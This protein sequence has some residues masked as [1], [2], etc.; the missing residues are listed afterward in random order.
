M[1]VGESSH[2]PIGSELVVDEHRNEAGRP[3]V[4]TNGLTG[5]LDLQRQIL[6]ARASLRLGETFAEFAARRPQIVR[7][8]VE[9]II[10]RLRGVDAFDVLELLRNREIMAARLGYSEPEVPANPKTLE[11]VGTIL[12]ARGAR[13]V[14]TAARSDEG[15]RAMEMLHIVGSEIGKAGTFSALAEAGRTGD[16]WARLG[17]AFRL[18]RLSILNLHYRSIDDSINRRLFGEGAFA[19]A[20]SQRL[21]FTWHDFQRVRSAIL[22]GYAT[23]LFGAFEALADEEDELHET[24]ASPIEEDRERLRALRSSVMTHPGHRASFRVE[25]IAQR[26][27][28]AIE[29]TSKILQLFSVQFSPTDPVEAVEAYL[30][31][32]SPFADAALIRD[33]D[34]NYL[35]LGLE[36]GDDNYR[37]ITERSLGRDAIQRL[38]NDHRKDVSEATAGEYLR[39][40]L[41]VDPAASG[42]YYYAEREGLAATELGHTATK[43]TAVGKECEGDLLFLVDDV[44]ICVEVKG[45][46]FSPG[47]RSTRPDYFQN[48][49]RKTI[50]AG[51]HQARRVANLIR[52]NGGLWQRDRTWLDLSHVR[53]V[54]TVVVTLD[55]LGPLGSE[56]ADLDEADV[57]PRDE[58]SWIVSTYDL[59]IIADLIQDTAQFLLYLRRRTDPESADRWRVVDELDLVML[60]FHTALEHQPDPARIIAEY[61][62]APAPGSDEQTLWDDQPANSRVHDYTTTMLNPWYE[63]QQGDGPEAAKPELS[64]DPSV[65]ALVRAFTTSGMNGRTV[66]AADLLG[67]TVAQRSAVRSFVDNARK[68]AGSRRSWSDCLSLAGSSGAGAIVVRSAPRGSE[69]NDIERQLRS[70]SEFVLSTWACDRVLSIAIGSAGS[71]VMIGQLILRSPTSGSHPFHQRRGRPDLRAR[72]DE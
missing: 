56:I 43:P 47:A 20:L 65:A 58:P 38:Y 16:P 63:F 1:S 71:P 54:R 37:Q 31:G 34:D 40:L 10:R 4:Y 22:D 18:A 30:R 15:Q 46:S 44:A 23:T 59:A 35:Q 8:G 13:T 27:G 42:Y 53:E 36:I 32:A 39:R 21:G 24:G 51:A 41:N 52:A 2:L 7:D 72:G 29:V 60:F 62:N 57:M 55:D 17:A 66:A 61:P 25:E 50:G 9:K 48:E 33:D 19:A 12:L 69:A 64:V 28:V 49:V 45:A 14:G 11:I 6:D 67:L 3:T 70:E 68:M 26:S 5:N